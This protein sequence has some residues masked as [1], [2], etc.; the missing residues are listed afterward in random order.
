MKTNEAKIM[1]YLNFIVKIYNFI[2]KFSW[3]SLNRK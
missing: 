1:Y 2:K 3:Q